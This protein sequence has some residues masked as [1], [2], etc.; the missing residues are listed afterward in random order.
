MNL[1][2]NLAEYATLFEENGYSAGEMFD[3][4]QAGLEG[5]AYNLDKVNDLVEGV[6]YSSK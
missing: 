6:W 2:D 4:L 5:G 3:I 1:G